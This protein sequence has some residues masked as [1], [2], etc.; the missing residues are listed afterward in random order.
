MAIFINNTL[1]RQRGKISLV[2]HIQPGGLQQMPDC[3]RGLQSAQEADDVVLPEP[4][5]PVHE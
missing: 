2:L 5:E 1:K 3:S 4:V